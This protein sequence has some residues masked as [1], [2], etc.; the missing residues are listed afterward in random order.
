MNENMNTAGFTDKIGPVLLLVFVLSLFVPPEARAQADAYHVWL[1]SQLETEYG[2]T[3]GTWLFG[4]REEE[5]MARM[6][7]SG[8]VNPQVLT[9][10]DQLFGI[11]LRL[12]VPVRGSNPW[13]Y[14]VGFSPQQGLAMGD[15]ALLVLWVRNIEAERGNGI[16]S[17]NVEANAPPWTKSM[18]QGMIPSSEWQQWLIPFEASINHPAD[19]VQAIFHLGTMAQTVEIGGLAILNYEK[20]YTLDEL[21]NSGQASTYAGRASDAPWR[22]E[23]EARIEQHRKRDLEIQVLDNRGI[24][25]EGAT[26]E[27]R[28]KRHHF[29][30]GTAV[31]VWQYLDQ[32]SN[33]RIYR[34]KL[35]D[36][37]GDG[38]TFSTSALE[39]A[40]KWGPWENPLWP[41]D[42]TQT[43]RVLA[44]LKALGMTVR[45]HNLVWPSWDFMPDAARQLEHDPTALRGLIE[46]RIADVAGRNGIK[47]ELIDWDVLNEP[48]HLHDVVQALANTPGYPTGE[49]VYAEWFNQAATI[50]P[51]AKRYI[52]EYGI[53]TNSGLDLATQANYKAIIQKI[54]TDGGKIDGVGL[55]GHFSLPLTPPETIYEIL[56]EYSNAGLTPK[57]IAITEYDAADVPEELAADYIE[58]L[59]TISFSHPAVKSFLMW[60]FWDG[61]HWKDDAPLFRRDWSTK[62]SGQAFIDLVFDTW[63]TD[64]ESMTDADGKTAIRGFHGDYEV[65]VT[66]EETS[67]T[68]PVALIPGTDAA[69]VQI[70]LPRQV[71]VD[72]TANFPLRHT[73]S[74][75]FPEPVAGITTFRFAL[76]T[77]APVKFELYDLLGRRVDIILE[78][79][80]PSGWHEIHYETS[81][82]PTGV[83]LYCLQSDNWQGHG[84]LTVIR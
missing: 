47:G 40:L 80:R 70:V 73:L 23:A 34:E 81:H 12:T 9:L 16:I 7:N 43:I 20:T 46:A 5:T 79:S 41:A 39:N 36:L 25:V 3:G 6:F 19:Q 42:Q 84:K 51:V 13:D 35:A 2:V 45:G 30:F 62:P 21:P 77:P 32:S 60:G 67:L 10:T 55:Q 31:A 15:R 49:E 53:L 72:E 37:T 18:E 75:H 61:A 24:A 27:I 83:Y 68:S 44:E 8:N 69:A 38:R 71:S 58:D 66:Y 48:A 54:E 56:D 65:T 14:F 33:G 63:W 52:N 11:G 29:G 78:A 1:K 64:A 82:L 50:D 28:M 22:A 59:L 76:P 17:A 57:E 74:P 4:D 26:V